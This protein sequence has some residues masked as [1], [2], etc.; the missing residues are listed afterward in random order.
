MRVRGP[1]VALGGDGEDQA[2]IGG[3]RWPGLGLAEKDEGWC[4]AAEKA[5]PHNDDSSSLD[6]YRGL[7]HGD[8]GFRGG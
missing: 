2:D 3:D 7:D 5:R 6:T 4:P 1:A 8:V